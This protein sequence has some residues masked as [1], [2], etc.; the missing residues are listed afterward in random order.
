MNKPLKWTL[1]LTAAGVGGYYTV[2]GLQR[3]RSSARRG[4]RQAEQVAQ[5][6]RETASQVEQTLHSAR[7]SI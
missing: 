5:R 6:A 3:A 2:L 7:T 4:L 1:L